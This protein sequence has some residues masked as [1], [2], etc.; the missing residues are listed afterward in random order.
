MLAL[1]KLGAAFGLEASGIDLS[2]PLEPAQFGEIWD[3]FFAGQVPRTA[4]ETS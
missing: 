4:W 1:E 3:A 2:R